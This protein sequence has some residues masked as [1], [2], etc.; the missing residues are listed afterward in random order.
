LFW[1]EAE[2]VLTYDAVELPASFAVWIVSPEAEFLRG[3]FVWSNWDVEELKA[4]KDQ[5]ISSQDL[6]LGLLGW[7]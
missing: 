4:K 7:P 6:T 1:S 5:L 3:K 2:P